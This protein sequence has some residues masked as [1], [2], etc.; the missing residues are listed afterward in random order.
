MKQASTMMMPNFPA[1][2]REEQA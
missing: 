1:D 2:A